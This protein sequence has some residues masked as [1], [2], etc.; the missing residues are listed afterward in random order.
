MASSFRLL[1]VLSTLSCFCC[2]VY[3]CSRPGLGWRIASRRTAAKWVIADQLFCS[4]SLASNAL[5]VVHWE[6]VRPLSRRH[7][8]RQAHTPRRPPFFLLARGSYSTINPPPQRP[9]IDPLFGTHGRPRRRFSLKSIFFIILFFLGFFLICFFVSHLVFLV[10]KVV[11]PPQG[12]EAGPA[13]RGAFGIH[14]GAELTTEGHRLW[15]ALAETSHATASRFS[16][17]VSICTI[18]VGSLLVPTPAPTPTAA[19]LLR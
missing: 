7:A 8:C 1:L 19:A 14:A 6:N 4:P 16:R 12:N 9:S 17:L 13:S 11:D 18:A 2:W 10:V 3:V 5:L 15:S